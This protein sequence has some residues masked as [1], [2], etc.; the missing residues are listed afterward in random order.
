MLFH[1][2]TSA[3]KLNHAREFNALIRIKNLAEC[4]K[5]YFIGLILYSQY[6]DKPELLSFFLPLLFIS[7][8]ISF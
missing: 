4:V 6:F 8:L 3:I 7:H 2:M 5:G 1:V